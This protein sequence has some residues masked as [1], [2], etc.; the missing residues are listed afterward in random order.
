MQKEKN[1]KADVFLLKPLC[2]FIISSVR[3]DSQPR[4]FPSSQT[5]NY[6]ANLRNTEPWPKASAHILFMFLLMKRVTS[7]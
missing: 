3:V 1:K 4:S 5:R 2:R 7:K 6:F